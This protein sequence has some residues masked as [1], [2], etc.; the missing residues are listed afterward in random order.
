MKIIVGP[1]KQSKYSHHHCASYSAV[2]HK[3]LRAKSQIPKIPS[4]SHML[5]L[6]ELQKIKADMQRVSQSIVLMSARKNGSS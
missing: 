5:R 2:S 4:I 6:G 3:R 1:S